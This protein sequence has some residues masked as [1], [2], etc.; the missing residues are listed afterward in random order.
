[1]V[2]PYSL[3]VLIKNCDVLQMLTVYGNA[4]TRFIFTHFE[5]SMYLLCEN[6]IFVNKVYRLFML[7]S[8]L[9]WFCPSQFDP[10]NLNSY[11]A[12]VMNMGG[13]RYS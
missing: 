5:I 3:Q 12:Y 2:S 6:H 11:E 13:A 8:F 1:M 7:S 10:L 4:I 9:Q